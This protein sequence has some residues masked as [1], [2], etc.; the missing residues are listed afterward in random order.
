VNVR[1]TPPSISFSY[2]HSPGSSSSEYFTVL[3]GDSALNIFA[4]HNHHHFCL[5]ITS[6]SSSSSSSSFTSYS[7]SHRSARSSCSLQLSSF[8]SNLVRLSL[9]LVLD[10]CLRLRLHHLSLLIVDFQLVSLRPRPHT[11][12]P[13]PLTTLSSCSNTCNRHP[14]AA[15]VPLPLSLPII[16]VVLPPQSTVDPSIHQTTIH[17]KR[18]Y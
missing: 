1:H 3:H 9:S 2:G 12:H 14:Q 11:P 10:D 18:V 8:T 13:T 16:L 4:N 7:F 15:R 17:P 6:S 5:L